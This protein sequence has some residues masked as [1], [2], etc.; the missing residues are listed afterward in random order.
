MI[1]RGMPAASRLR[2]S[3]ETAAG[4]SGGVLLP[5]A[6]CPC[7]AACC[8]STF[9]DPKGVFPCARSR[10][11]SMACRAMP[12]NTGVLITDTSAIAD[13]RYSGP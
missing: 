12:R 5:G 9:V 10:I 3:R 2:A 6:T 8:A 1:R 7:T 13:N 4:P 11:A